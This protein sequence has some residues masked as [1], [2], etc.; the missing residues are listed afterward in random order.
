[1]E[2]LTERNETG[3]AIFSGNDTPIGNTLRL[4]DILETLAKYEE[5]GLTPEQVTAMKTELQDER[6]RHDRQADFTVG[7]AKVMDELRSENA[8]LKQL[9]ELARGERDVVTKRMIELE[10]QISEVGRMKMKIKLDPGAYWPT[11]AH[12]L[13]GGLDLYSPEETIVFAGGSVCIDTG[14]HVAIPEGYAGLLVSKSGLNVNHNITN[15]GLIDAGYTG[16]IKIK[17]YN[18]GNQIVRIG[19]GQKIS[20]LLILP[21]V[22]PDL[23]LVEELDE[24]ERGDGG[25]GSTGAF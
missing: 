3:R 19:H 8:H 16:S 6:Y 23:E 5:T 12:K 17:L 24:T 14:V 7:Q 21:F 20:Q 15:D 18:H 2:R 13:D 25:F 10:Q 1:M 4:G 9:L 22:A 11:R